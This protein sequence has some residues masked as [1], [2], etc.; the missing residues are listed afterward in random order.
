[1]MAT[2]IAS[3]KRKSKQMS[4]AEKLLTAEEYAQ[5][6]DDGRLSELVRG[7][8]VY[9][10]PTKSRHGYVCGNI[11]GIVRSFVK[12][13]DLGRSLCNDSGVI[14]ERDPD[15]VR[16]ADV[17]YYSYT[18]LA[19]GRLPNRYPDTA[20]EVVFE[21]L[22]P[23]DRWPQVLAKVSEYLNAGVLAVCVADPERETV[24]LHRPDEPAQILTGDRELCLPEIHA[25]FRVP[26]PEFFE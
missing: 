24:H 20:P 23:D 4:V 9:M 17:S 10:N 6:P 21:V 18:R 26:V 12:P 13:R 22:S 8:V 19:K 7:R 11:Q 15:T 1:M 14:T 16:G 2:S 25:D 3:A 5:L